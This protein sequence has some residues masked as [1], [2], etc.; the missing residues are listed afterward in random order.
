MA[1]Q[2]AGTTFTHVKARWLTYSRLLSRNGDYDVTLYEAMNSNGLDGYAMDVPVDHPVFKNKVPLHIGTSFGS[3]SEKLKT[4]TFR[5]NFI[6]VHA[7]DVPVDHLVFKNTAVY[8]SNSVHS[9]QNSN[10]FI[11]GSL[12]W[13]QSILSFLG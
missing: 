4:A 7:M 13:F 6:I 8:Y 9:N 10:H 5:H 12:D 3:M 11:A 1:S 2:L